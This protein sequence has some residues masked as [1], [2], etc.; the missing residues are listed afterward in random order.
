MK[1]KDGKTKVYITENGHTRIIDISEISEVPVKG[2]RDITE[3]YYNA[4]KEEFEKLGYESS[5]SYTYYEVYE[6]TRQRMRE[7][8]YDFIAV[9]RDNLPVIDLLKKVNPFNPFCKIWMPKKK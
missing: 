5:Q 4:H 3:E 8:G 2:E 7:K 6:M 9:F 1:T